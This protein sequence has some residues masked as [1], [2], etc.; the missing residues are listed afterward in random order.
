MNSFQESKQEL[1]AAIRYAENAISSANATI[2]SMEFRQEIAKKQHFK[3]TG[4]EEALTKQVQELEERND[5]LNIQIVEQ[6]N[7][8]ATLERE[9]A[10]L[11]TQLVEERNRSMGYTNELE[12]LRSEKEASSGPCG[13]QAY[14][15][16][17][18]QLCVAGGSVHYHVN[19]EAEL[20]DEIKELESEVENLKIELKDQRE[21]DA[22]VRQAVND[23]LDLLDAIGYE[24]A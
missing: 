22:D 10:E 21:F 2:E 24:R 6:T 1:E 12:K 11:K 19:R 5:E 13:C 8:E 17:E 3:Q 23:L 4:R 15:D 9:V 20:L 7:R 18:E 14:R 16:L